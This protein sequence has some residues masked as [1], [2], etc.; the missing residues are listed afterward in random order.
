[1]SC[2]LHTPNVSDIYGIPTLHTIRGQSCSG[3]WAARQQGGRGVAGMFG[4]P[5]A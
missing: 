4:I 2:F 3:E 1:M 5:P